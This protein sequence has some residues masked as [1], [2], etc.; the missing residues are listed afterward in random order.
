MFLNKNVY[1]LKILLPDTNVIF[2]PLVCGLS[3]LGTVYPMPIF[4]FRTGDS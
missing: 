4:E 2:L 3:F 1:N